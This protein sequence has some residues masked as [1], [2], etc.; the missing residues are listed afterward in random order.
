MEVDAVNPTICRSGERGLLVAWQALI[1]GR[2]IIQY[3]RFDGESWGAIAIASGSEGD[4][5]RP[6]LVENTATHEDWLCWD[7]YQELAYAVFARRLGPEPGPIERVSPP[8]AGT[9]ARTS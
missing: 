5:F 1:E 8:G 2:M 3:R 9:N 6:V 7:A 4:A